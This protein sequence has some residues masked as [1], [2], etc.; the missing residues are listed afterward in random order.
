MRGIEKEKFFLEMICEIFQIFLL[1][2]NKFFCKIHFL[3]LF[4]LDFY[5]IDLYLIFSICTLLALISLNLAMHGMKL[6]FK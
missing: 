1:R 3:L 4:Y 2:E 5:H 6:I